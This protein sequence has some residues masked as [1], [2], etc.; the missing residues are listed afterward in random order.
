MIYYNK[1]LKVVFTTRCRPYGEGSPSFEGTEEEFV[2]P[3]AQFCSGISQDDADSQARA[4]ADANGQAW[5]DRIGGCP[6]IYTNDFMEQ[7]FYSR[8]CEEGT[9]QE[10]PTV[11]SVSPGTFFSCESKE[12][13]NY[14]A[15]K[16]IEKEGRAEAD[17]NGKCKPVYY[18]QSQHGWFSKKCRPGWKGPEKYK[19]IEA[20][21]A[22]S[23]ISV[24]DANKK[25]MEILKE[26]AQEWV[27]YNTECEPI[28]DPCSKF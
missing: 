21:A 7:E 17:I 5:A 19:S 4:W 20:G 1:L 6:E 26:Q 15:K 8:V 23:F 2:V 3:E 11:V 16:S 12:A 13:A 24:E 10:E 14:C 28:V 22:V 18:S 9:M 25:A 27:D